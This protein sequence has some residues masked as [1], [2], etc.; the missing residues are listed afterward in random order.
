M[1]W[2]W[3]KT[4][5]FQKPLLIGVLLPA[6]LYLTSVGAIFAYEF[7][8]D[9]FDWELYVLAVVIWNTAMSLG[10]AWMTIFGIAAYGLV[11]GR[12]REIPDVFA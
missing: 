6:S 11:I 5:P 3:D 2:S 1:R 12:D 9:S 4:E 7:Y 10:I 8:Y